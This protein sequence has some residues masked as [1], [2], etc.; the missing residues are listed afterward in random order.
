MSVPTYHHTKYLSNGI[1]DT[2]HCAFEA[3]YHP[4]DALSALPPRCTHVYNSRPPKFRYLPL[5]TIFEFCDE[6]FH[7]TLGRWEIPSE[8]AVET[9]AAGNILVPA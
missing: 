9:N 2:R 5:T 3:G 7:H 1:I 4:F 8:A 6:E